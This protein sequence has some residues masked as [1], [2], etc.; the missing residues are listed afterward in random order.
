MAPHT[1]LGPATGL[2]LYVDTTPLPL[3]T[4]ARGQ[5]ASAGHPSR[6]LVL[7]VL[8]LLSPESSRILHGCHC[9]LLSSGPYQLLPGL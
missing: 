5:G 4:E 9:H 1:E 6:P 3:T 8:S 7:Q 2:T